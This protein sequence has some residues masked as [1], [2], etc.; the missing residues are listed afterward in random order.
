M[1]DGLAGGWDLAR[2]QARSSEERHTIWR[3]ALRKGDAEALALARFIESSGLEYAEKGGIS[4]SDPRVI[5]MREVIESPEG[6]EACVEAV[7]NGLP[8]LAGVEPLI[9]AKMGNRYG[10]FSQMTV[11]AGSIVGEMM[12]GLGYRIA[13][14]RK[15]PAG[16]VAKTAAF[17]VAASPAGAKV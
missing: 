1:S 2:L 14:Q 9:A 15:M 7:R 4:M 16:S 3:N 13:G 12:P 5:E 8:A 10:S 6:R 17:W 11:T